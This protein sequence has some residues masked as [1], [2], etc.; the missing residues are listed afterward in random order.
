M[1]ASIKSIEAQIAALTATVATLAAVVNG[2]AT[3]KAAAEPKAAQPKADVRYRS[4]SA[5]AKGQTE[6]AEIYARHYAAAGAKRWADLT[7]AQ[8]TAAKAE[9]RSAWKAIKG[10]RKTAV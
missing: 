6:Q 2:S 4:A 5:I 8:Q 9:V 7:A 10:T 1:A 3:V